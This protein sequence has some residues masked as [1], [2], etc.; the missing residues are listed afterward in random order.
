MNSPPVF[1]N[2][3][4]YFIIIIISNQNLKTCRFTRQTNKINLLYF[5]AAVIYGKNIRKSIA[6]TSITIF[7]EYIDEVAYLSIFPMA[8]LS[9]DIANAS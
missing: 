9:A 6:L 1:R 5:T 2:Y 7:L 8:S 4:Y 3:N